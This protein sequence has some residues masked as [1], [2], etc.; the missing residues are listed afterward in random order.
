LDVRQ[1]CSS[2]F[3]VVLLQQ[4]N[5]E[6]IEAEAF[7]AASSAATVNIGGAFIGYEDSVDL[8][9]CKVWPRWQF[10]VARR[11]KESNSK[12]PCFSSTE[13]VILWHLL[14]AKGDTIDTFEIW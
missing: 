2:W 10:T 5:P 8:S 4:N 14:L 12:G 9:V 7:F 11:K 13:N 1:S 3:R 6:P